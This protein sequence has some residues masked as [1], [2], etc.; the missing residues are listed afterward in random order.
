[1]GQVIFILSVVFIGKGRGVPGTGQVIFVLSVV[2]KW[3]GRWVQ[4]RSSLYILFLS[5]DRSL[6]FLWLPKGK[7]EWYRTA[8][9]RIRID[10][11]RI[12]IQHFF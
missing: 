4:D 2:T 8:G 1:M 11:M 7:E 3:K 6:Y 12:R 9:F 5:K 10:L